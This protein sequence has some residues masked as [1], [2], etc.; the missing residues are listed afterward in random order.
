V[1]AD[2]VKRVWRKREDH[3]D[4]LERSE[5]QTTN[6]EPT[7]TRTEHAEALNGCQYSDEQ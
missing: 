4:E 1:A 3:A 2:I 6:A 5:E 7:Q